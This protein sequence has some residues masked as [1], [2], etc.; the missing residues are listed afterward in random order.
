MDSQNTRNY[1]FMVGYHRG[2]SRVISAWVCLVL[3]LQTLFG[4]SVDFNTICTSLN[5]GFT[6]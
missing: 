5:D 1:G 3:L 2:K 4:F 6:L